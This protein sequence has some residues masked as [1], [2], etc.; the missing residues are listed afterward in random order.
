MVRGVAVQMSSPSNL[1]ASVPTNVTS[2]PTN[3]PMWA[4]AL[5]L[6]AAAPWCVGLLQSAL[7]AR[8]RERTRKLLRDLGLPTERPA[9]ERQPGRPDERPHDPPFDRHDRPGSA[10]RDVSNDDDEDT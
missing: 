2:V 8:R 10:A 9:H 7:E 1:P 4:V 5:V 6:A 3:V